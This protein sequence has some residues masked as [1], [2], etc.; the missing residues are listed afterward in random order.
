MTLTIEPIAAPETLDGADDFVAYVEVRNAVEAHS[1]G[2]RLLAMAPAEIRPEYV[3]NPHR[4]R[5]LLAARV[6]GRIVGRAMVTWRPHDLDSGS[7]LMV[8]VLPAHRGRGIGT[9]LLAA[10]EEIALERA[11]PVLKATLPHGVDVPGE[12]VVPPTGHGELSAGDPG[13]RFLV[14]NGYGLEQV[15]RIGV[16]D[17]AGLAERLVPLRQQA[18][19]RV[20]EAY[21]LRTWTGV[22]PPEWR[23]DL[24][25]LRERMSTDAPSGA[26][27]VGAEP[28]DAERVVAHDERV[29]AMG[30][31]ML[32]A[33][34]EHVPTGRLVGFTEIA[35]VGD[36][37]KAVQEDTLVL[38]EH[39]GHRLGLRLK[40]E[41]A[42]LLL[43]HAPGVAA[44]VTWNA[45]ENA[46][47][48]DVNEAMGFRAIGYEGAWQKRVA[49][50]DRARE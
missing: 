23:D 12:R 47:M 44:V 38:R 42:G 4:A 46:P 30:H 35:V 34:A 21:R 45:E 32:T 41:T 6:D 19:A 9:A 13:V 33:A 3:D 29:V 25:R 20:G 1:V 17:T 26:M 40:T 22:T 36:G 27:L 28:W 24:A 5:R 15:T 49:G 7:Y 2:S 43:T 48:L 16:L 18:M 37:S 50:S 31:T 11:A 14:A 39:R 8:D 10:A